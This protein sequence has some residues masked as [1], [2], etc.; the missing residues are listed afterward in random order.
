M[1]RTIRVFLLLP[2]LASCYVYRP[3]PGVGAIR[4]DR[5]RLTLTDS[6]AL[7]LA[8]QLGPSTEELSGR[9]L[10][11]SAGVYVVAVV[12][13]RRQGGADMDWRGERVA[14]PRPFVARAEERRFSRKR[15]IIASVALVAAALAARE[16]FW[17]PGGVFGGAPPGGGPTPR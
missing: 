17:G 11:D 7:A 6:G 10:R 9:V 15:T 3:V 16:A 13:T 12:G 2:L 5:I 4:S 8:A 14:I 1:T